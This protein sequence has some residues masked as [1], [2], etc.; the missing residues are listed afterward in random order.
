MSKY[1][2]AYGF[3]YIAHL[4]NLACLSSFLFWYAQ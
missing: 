1:S 3:V 4:K 2:I